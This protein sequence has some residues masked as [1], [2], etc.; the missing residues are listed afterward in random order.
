MRV[1]L[2]VCGS[3]MT[4]PVSVR[5]RRMGM[6]AL[7]TEAEPAENLVPHIQPSLGVAALLT[8]IW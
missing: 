5:L 2:S 6:L 3:G 1:G 4:R 7:A 8:D